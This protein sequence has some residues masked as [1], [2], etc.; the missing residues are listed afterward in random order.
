MDSFRRN[1]TRRIVKIQKDKLPS[2]IEII[3][4]R[5]KENR[6]QYIDDDKDEGSI[7]KF[8]NYAEKFKVVLLVGHVP[9]KS[10]KLYDN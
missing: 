6:Y 4:L 1:S 7:S 9:K 3:D 10:L 8:H 5:R 2:R